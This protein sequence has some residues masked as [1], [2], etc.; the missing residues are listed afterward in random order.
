MTIGEEWKLNIEELKIQKE[1]E[2]E[3]IKQEPEC[4]K[5]KYWMSEIIELIRYAGE[6]GIEYIYIS[7]KDLK[8]IDTEQALRLLQKEELFV[9]RVD[10]IG[11]EQDGE[12]M[13]TYK[14]MQNFRNMFRLIPLKTD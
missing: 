13:I 7:S 3:P 14:E 5:V 10:K 6:S 12:I 9:Y 4:E 2:K 11:H 8:S 1:M